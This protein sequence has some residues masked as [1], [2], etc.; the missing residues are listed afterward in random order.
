MTKE[1]E[2]TY[3]SHAS[4]K[5]K[6]EFGTLVTDPWILNEPV[7][8]FTTWKFPAAVM[9]PEEVFSDADYIYFSH[10]H[11]D[12][13]HIPSINHIPRG[14]KIII[15]E[16]TSNPG[17]RAQTMERTLRE[18][19]FYNVIKLLP[20][21]SLDLGGGAVFTLIPACKM[22]YWD[23]ENS[24]FVLE[25][26]GCKLLNMNDCP[27][28]PELYAEVDKRFGEFDIG[29]VQYAGVSMFPGCY[30][31]SDEEMKQAVKT[32]RT[33][34]TQQKNMVELLK[35][36]RL[37]PFAGDFCWLDERM[38]HCNWTNRATPR[39]FE[40]FVRD[41]YQEKN[42]EM[43]V[44]YP[45]DK[46]SVGQG[47]T[48]NH[49]EIDWDNYQV[50]IDRLRDALKPKV[51]ALR[52]WADGASLADL[53]KRSRDYTA[54]LERWFPKDKVDFSARVRFEIEGAKAGF[55][56]VMKSSPETGVVID[57]ND[58]GDVDQSLFV[59]QETWAAVLEGRM[60]MNNLQWAAENKQHVPFRLEIARF[61]FW[62][63][64]FIDLN[65]R[66]PQALIDS[67]L[68]PEIKERI[69]PELGI[70]PLAGEWD[71]KWLVRR[72]AKKTA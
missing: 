37:A 22:K 3:V 23:W 46:W 41:T 58:K 14:T 44:M 53:E 72:L 5:L 60:L 25:Y 68:H 2:V 57:W 48:R 33:G 64:T 45:S 39:L 36:K 31:M 67:A 17:L 40:D 4:I 16:Y 56:F 47:L 70:F 52:K 9:P 19:G 54:N 29:F 12:H 62:F 11:E 55:S 65:N 28:D 66:N 43:V 51:A 6:G 24:G 50:E 30:R 13:F 8:N 20:W 15:A 18:M 38:Y 59:R 34:W 21:Q 27:S 26:P 1:L 49:P 35:V 61:W 32:R 7:Y 69:R 10:P 71:A 63:E 42:I